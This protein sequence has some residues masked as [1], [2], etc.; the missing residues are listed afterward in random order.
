MGYID[1]VAVTAAVYFLSDKNALRNAAIVGMIHGLLHG[2]ACDKL[3][4]Q[5][6]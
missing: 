2:Y 1:G 5:E 3:H 4:E 6:K